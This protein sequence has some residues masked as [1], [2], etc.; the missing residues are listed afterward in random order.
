MDDQSNRPL[1]TQ[2]QDT[3]PTQPVSAAPDTDQSENDEHSFVR[4]Y[5]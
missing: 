1:D 4:G 2:P 5:N 3:A